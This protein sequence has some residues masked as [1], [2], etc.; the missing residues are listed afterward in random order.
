MLKKEINEA[1]TAEAGWGH[2]GKSSVEELF[3]SF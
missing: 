3:I 2:S 1:T